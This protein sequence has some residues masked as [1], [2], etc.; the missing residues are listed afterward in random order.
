MPA[1]E[2]QSRALGGFW[3]IAAVVRRIEELYEREK[4]NASKVE[5]RVRVYE[6]E[7][8]ARRGAFMGISKAALQKILLI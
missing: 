2:T 5:G 6:E 3:S 1:I 7:K 4:R 8:S